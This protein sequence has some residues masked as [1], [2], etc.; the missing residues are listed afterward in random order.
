LWQHRVDEAVRKH[1]DRLRSKAAR[2]YQRKR[3]GAR[4]S[5]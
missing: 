5:C 1:G 4:R 3:S 2:L